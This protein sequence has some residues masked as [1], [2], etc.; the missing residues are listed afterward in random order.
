[1]RKTGLTPIST[2]LTAAIIAGGKSCR[3]GQPKALAR[4]DEKA[5]IDYA[6]DLAK[7]ISQCVILSYGEENFYEDKDALKVEDII[8]NCGPIGGIYSA[9]IHTSTPWIAVLPCDLPLLS[10]SVYK[11]LF[12]NRQPNHPVVARSGQGLEPLV[13]I[14]PKSLATQLYEAIQSGDFSLYKAIKRLNCVEIYM[15]GEMS[16]YD[17]SIF[18]NINCAEDLRELKSRFNR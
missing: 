1:M 7:S 2:D 18:F 4:F 11:I 15:P 9:L 16:E 3:F 5:L 6:L 10:P 13:S 17:P 12:A 8:K 14:W